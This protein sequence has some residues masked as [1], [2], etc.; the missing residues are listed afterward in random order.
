MKIYDGLKRGLKVLAVKESCK[1]AITKKPKTS[2][3]LMMSKTS[4][5]FVRMIYFLTPY[6]DETQRSHF[7][8]YGGYS[9]EKKLL[10]KIELR[11]V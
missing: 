5:I 2:E 11:N 4:A 9:K 8:K 7:K 1:P 6:S 3:S 10:G